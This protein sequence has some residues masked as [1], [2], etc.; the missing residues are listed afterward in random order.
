MVVDKPWG[1]ELIWAKT[2]RYV[3]KILHIRAGE[4]LSLQ[5]HRVKD[6]TIMVMRGRMQ[7][8]Y[9]PDGDQPRS[10]EL[11][12][13][14]PFHITPG[15]RH[16]MIAIEDTDVLEVS[17]PEIDDVVRLEDRYGRSGR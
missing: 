4:A 7:L 1:H 15:L 5:Y 2:E 6:E 3:G 12:V 14:E 9:F 13:L 11:T 8:I 10:R 16:R 17:T